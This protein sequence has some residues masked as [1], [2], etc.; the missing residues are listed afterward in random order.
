LDHRINSFFFLNQNDVVLVKKK[1]KSTGY[2]HIFDRVLP[3]RP[4]ESA[5]SHQI[6]PSPVF[7]LIQPASSSERL[8]PEPVR[9]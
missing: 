4:A 9:F 8:D 6:F 2:N 1:Q 5:G 7:F 3:G